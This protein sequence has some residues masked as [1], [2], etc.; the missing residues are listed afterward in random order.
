M[1]GEPLQAGQEDHSPPTVASV[2]PATVLMDW[3]LPLCSNFPLL[4]VI[5]AFDSQ[6]FELNT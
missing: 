1:L 3:E 5:Y 6:S 4:V 2:E